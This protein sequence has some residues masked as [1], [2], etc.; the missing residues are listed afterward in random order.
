MARGGDGPT[1]APAGRRRPRGGGHA[2][3]GAPHESQRHRPP[4]SGTRNPSAPA[5]GGRQARR[6]GPGPGARSSGVAAAKKDKREPGLGTG[7]VFC[8]VPDGSGET[9][10]AGGVRARGGLPGAWPPD[11]RPGGSPSRRPPRPL[12]TAPAR[13]PPLSRPAPSWRM[14]TRSAPPLPG[15]PAPSPR[16]APQ[17]QS[18]TSKAGIAADKNLSLGTKSRWQELSS[19]LE[20]QRVD[21]HRGA[22]PFCCG[23][24]AR[25]R[26]GS[27]PAGV[28]E[29]Q[30]SPG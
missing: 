8:R 3:A 6:A 5:L 14:Q 17:P 29:Q 1:P 21:T 10:E 30:R 11:R 25:E 24:R 20:G 4:P 16:P 2:P 12:G 19:G 27:G 28:P 13:P 7:K 23:P 18:C 26:R 9:E 22:R 15:P